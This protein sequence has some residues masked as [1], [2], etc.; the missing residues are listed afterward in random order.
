M[1]NNKVKINVEGFPK[2]MIFSAH[3]ATDNPEDLNIEI[4]YN[5]TGRSSVTWN[6]DDSYF[7]LSGGY[8]NKVFISVNTG[9]AGTELNFIKTSILT[10]VIGIFIVEGM[11]GIN[12]ASTASLP[13]LIKVEIYE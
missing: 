6:D 1:E 7:E 2:T 5:T 9:I 11:A 3:S 4:L 12:T 8:L 10:G 13:I